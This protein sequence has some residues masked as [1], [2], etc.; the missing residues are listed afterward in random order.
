[1]TWLIWNRVRRTVLLEKSRGGGESG[2]TW[3]QSVKRG[4]DHGGPCRSLWD[5]GQLRV[6][7]WHDTVWVLL[8]SFSCCD[9]NGWE[10]WWGQEKIDQSGSYSWNLGKGSWWI[11]LFVKPLGATASVREEIKLRSW[12]QNKFY[13]TVTIVGISWY[14]P[15]ECDRSQELSLSLLRHLSGFSGISWCWWSHICIFLDRVQA[16]QLAGH[17]WPCP[18]ASGFWLFIS[19]FGLLSFSIIFSWEE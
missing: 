14:I 3:G 5:T 17:I 7:K 15:S 4:Q 2:K 16:C 10:K 6:E 11:L 18:P 13:R 12:G 9:G 1:M 8:R 19:W